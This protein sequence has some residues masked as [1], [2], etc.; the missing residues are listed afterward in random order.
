MRQDAHNYSDRCPNVNVEHIFAELSKVDVTKATGS[1]CV[2][3]VIIKAAAHVISGPIQHIV[4][5]SI[6]DKYVPVLW[7]TGL[8]KYKRLFIHFNLCSQ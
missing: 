6:V 1:D 5:C 2:P 4:Y 8:F 7:Q 3:P